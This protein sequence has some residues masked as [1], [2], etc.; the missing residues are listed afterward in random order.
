MFQEDFHQ[1]PYGAVLYDKEGTIID[2]NPLFELGVGVSKENLKAINIFERIIDQEILEAVE[3]SLEGKPG[4]Y[5]GIYHSVLGSN[6]LP[7]K[8]VFL[9]TRIVTGKQIGRAHV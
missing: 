5:E 9:G 1:L 4:Y 2:V 7:V 3:R 6:S 8:G